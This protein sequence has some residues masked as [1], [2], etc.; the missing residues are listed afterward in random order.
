MKL[1]ILCPTNIF[2]QN[3]NTWKNL[4]VRLRVLNAFQSNATLSAVIATSV[5]AE[6][7]SISCVDDASCLGISTR[8][9]ETGVNGTIQPQNETL[10]PRLPRQLV[11]SF[12]G[13]ELNANFDFSKEESASNSVFL[14]QCKCTEGWTITETGECSQGKKSW[15]VILG[16]IGAVGFSISIL[17]WLCRCF[18]K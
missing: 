5:F 11:P 9:G 2:L 10:H 3:P 17:C 13:K 12:C 15:I 4:R 8:V 6:L 7:A 14:L 16:V 18:A 1:N